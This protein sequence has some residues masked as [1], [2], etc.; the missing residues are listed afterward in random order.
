LEH[1]QIFTGK[2]P[3]YPYSE[4]QVI[5]LLS[6]DERPDKPTHGEFTSRM[7]TLTRKCWDKDPKKR[8]EI[9]DVLKTLESRDG[10]FSNI[11]PGCF[12]LLRKRTENNH[13]TLFP[14]SWA[15]L[16][17]RISLQLGERSDADCQD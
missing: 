8:P 16:G 15:F 6:R 11:H 17:S 14:P 5:F 10:A 9:L 2:V 1:I 13:Y 7:W 4:E 3:F 12:H